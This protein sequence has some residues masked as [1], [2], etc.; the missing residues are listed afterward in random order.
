MNAPNKPFA[1]IIVLCFNSLEITTKPCIESILKHTPKNSYELI[2]VDNASS[3][4]TTDYLKSLANRF[5]HIRLHLNKINRGFAGGN[6]DGLRLAQGDY[7]VLLN[8]DTL[9]P[10]H[11]LDRLLWLLQRTSQVGLVGPVTNSSGNEQN[12]ELP[13]ITEQNFQSVSERY[14]A[15]NRG[16][17]F[18]T[19]RLG[20]F[21]VAMSRSVF[22][23]TGFLDENFGIGMFEDDDYC[24]RVIKNGYKL[25]VVEDCFVYHKGSVAF[26]KLSGEKYR[27]LFETNKAYFCDKHQVQWTLSDIA[28][29]YIHKFD[30]DLQAYVRNNPITD[31]A[32]ERILVRVETF[33]QF[34]LHLQNSEIGVC[35]NLHSTNSNIRRNQWGVRRN[36]FRNE[37]ISGG[38]MQKINYIK[39]IA[40]FII[41]NFILR[42]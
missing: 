2:L 13:G 31:S 27:D 20:F 15:R 1:S 16:V 8:N 39:S 30:T 18:D 28:F 12:I 6:N 33:K 38:Y 14:I 9:L 22:E 3:D 21:C 36:V 5:S 40:S 34:L 35:K 17:W 19:T 41:H 11:W 25:A 32:L 7:L 24:L 37:F 23:K 26:K 42:R 10:E 4:G 29:S